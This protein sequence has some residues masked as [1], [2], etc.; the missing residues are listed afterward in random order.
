MTERGSGPEVSQLSGKNKDA[1]LRPPDEKQ[2]VGAP[3][4][5]AQHTAR[6][7]RFAPQC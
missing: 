4:W 5:G 6:S 7:E 2:S 3:G 1:R